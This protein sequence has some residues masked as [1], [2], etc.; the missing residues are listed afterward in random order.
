[1]TNLASILKGSESI[2]NRNAQM[3]YVG[4]DAIPSELLRLYFGKHNVDGFISFEFWA[5][6][7]R[8][9]FFC[10]R[11]P[12]SELLVYGFKNA[13]VWQNGFC[14]I[15]RKNPYDLAVFGIRPNVSLDVK[16]LL[17]NCV[18]VDTYLNYLSNYIWRCIIDK[19][20]VLLFAIASSETPGLFCAKGAYS[21][22]MEKTYVRFSE[23][24]PT[25]LN[26]GF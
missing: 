6:N 5:S 20:C 11:A 10:P 21:Y 26:L 25:I 18:G 16:D 19:R 14:Y 13:T 7:Y 24:D 9:K 2:A 22:S 1:M 23:T 12:E 8:R 15:E 17:V 4:N 3:G